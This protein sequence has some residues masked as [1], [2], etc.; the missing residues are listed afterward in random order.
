MQ[1]KDFSTA[2]CGGNLT[3]GRRFENVFLGNIVTSHI[4]QSQ[5]KD[6]AQIKTNLFYRRSIMTQISNEVR[7]FIQS[8]QRQ[9]KLAQ[10]NDIAIIDT[11]N[12]ISYHMKQAYSAEFEDFLVNLLDVDAGIKICVLIEYAEEIRMDTPSANPLQ[13]AVPGGMLCDTIENCLTVVQINKYEEEK[14]KLQI[15]GLTRSIEDILSADM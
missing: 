15:N 9:L 12:N 1:E 13:D 3:R 14:Q 7:H 2:Y 11:A 8:A 4:N 10:D 5:R 6:Y